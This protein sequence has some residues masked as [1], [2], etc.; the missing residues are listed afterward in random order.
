MTLI[1]LPLPSKQRPTPMSFLTPLASS[2]IGLAREPSCRHTEWMSH[3]AE[4]CRCKGSSD[5]LIPVYVVFN[6]NGRDLPRP[7]ANIEEMIDFILAQNRTLRGYL[8]DRLDFP[9]QIGTVSKNESDE[10]MNLAVFRAE[11]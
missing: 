7:P 2:T 5:V 3:S 11:G 1:Q 4:L 6:R 9:Q 10:G 8:R